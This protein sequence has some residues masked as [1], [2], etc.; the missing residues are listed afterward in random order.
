MAAGLKMFYARHTGKQ[1]K[2]MHISEIAPEDKDYLICRYCATRIVWVDSFKRLGKNIPAYLRLWPNTAHEPGCKNTMKSLVDALVAESTNIED[3][4]EVFAE[5]NGNY[6]FRMN[7]LVDA[8]RELKSAQKDLD[9]AAE[10]SEKER[11]RT[12]YQRTEKKLT[13]YFNSAAGIAKLRAR[14]EDSEDK[15]ELSKLVTIMFNKKKVSWNDFFFDEN[16][17]P[18]LFKKASKIDYPVAIALTVEKEETPVANGAFFTAKGETCRVSKED[19]EKDFFC[20]ELRSHTSGTL[21]K[22]KAKEEVI[23]VGW[24]NT[25]EAPWKHGITYKNIIFWIDNNKQITRVD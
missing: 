4:Q 22:F 12:H 1:N 19:G 14:I 8:V 6:V 16:R 24:L 7:V 2:K 3:A 9:E 13:D 11:K 25:K 20:P 15:E 17:Y 5:D 23:V 10:D 21:L 18:T